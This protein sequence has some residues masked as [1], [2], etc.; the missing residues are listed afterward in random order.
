M[1]DPTEGKPRRDFLIKSLVGA[2]TA[3]STVAQPL[4]A[5]TLSAKA[6]IAAPQSPVTASS[7]GYEWL[8]PAEQTFV[9]ALAVHMCPA[10]ANSPG[11]IDMGLA[12]RGGWCGWCSTR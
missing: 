8:R 2:A 3:A 11:G 1:Q 9:E 10:D 6:A 7:P 4:Q 5:Q 12:I